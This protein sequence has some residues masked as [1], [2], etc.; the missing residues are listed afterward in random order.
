[1]AQTA[2]DVSWES[3]M[4]QNEENVIIGER[5]GVSYLRSQ[6]ESVSLC[7]DDYTL[8]LYQSSMG[9]L[10]MSGVVWDAG[11]YLSDYLIANR[12]VASGR[13]LDI[14][15]GTGICGIAALFLGATSVTFTDAFIP[16]S[17]DDNLSQL[18]EE[19]KAKATFVPYN[20]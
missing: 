6:K 10:T 2:K 19:Q 12:T 17:L 1:M 9:I 15:C 7:V 14:G 11:L 13:V 18:S 5:L 16:P 8:Q 4:Y 20:W 3:I